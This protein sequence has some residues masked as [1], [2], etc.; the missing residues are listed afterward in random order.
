MAALR[1]YGNDVKDVSMKHFDEAFGRVTASITP[2][3]IKQYE[4]IQQ[5]LVGKREKLSLSYLA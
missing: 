4:E 2:E 5:K 1:E 3:M